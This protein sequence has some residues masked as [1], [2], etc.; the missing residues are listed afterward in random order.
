METAIERKRKKKFILCKQ[1]RSIHLLQSIQSLSV[2][3]ISREGCQAIVS[4]M[5]AYFF[6]YFFY[7]SPSITFKRDRKKIPTLVTAKICILHVD[8]SHLSIDI[9]C[10]II[11]RKGRD[12]CLF[13]T[14]F[15]HPVSTSELTGE[16]N[17]WYYL[18]KFVAFF[19]LN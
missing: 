4:K 16:V 8:I 3:Q 1:L 2:T 14:L 13:I 17:H 12:R 6:F 10:R 7:V 11:K 18:I 19:T 15:S 9:F 5:G